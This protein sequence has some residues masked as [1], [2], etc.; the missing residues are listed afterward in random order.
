MSDDKTINAWTTMGG[1]NSRAGRAACAFALSPKAT[2][3]RRAEG[4]IKASPVFSRD[5]VMFIADMTGLVR[6]LPPEGKPLWEKRLDASVFATPAVGDSVLYTATTSGRIYALN[7]A[8][9]D[10]IW[11]VQ[12]PSPDDPR[13]LSDLLLLPQFSLVIASSWG[14][15]FVA[16]DVQKHNER[17]SW[18]A[19][20]NPY[21]A[22]SADA[23]GAIYSL[24]AEWSNSGPNGTRLVRVD[25]QPGKETSLFFDEIK[26][27]STTIH[28]VAAAPVI[29]DERKTVWFITHSGRDST[30]WSLSLETGKEQI[31]LA[32][33]CQITAPPAILPDG[34]T[35]VADMQ[36]VVHNIAPNGE[37]RFRYNTG[38]DYLLS[39]PVC[40][41]DGNIFGGDVIGCLHAISPQGV[42]AIVFEAERGIEARPAFDPAGRLI[43]PATDGAI[44]SF[45]V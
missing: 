36:G 38:G 43:V 31:R 26:D 12:I 1:N 10:E 16:L 8:N 13:I 29:D 33:P 20:T 41:A 30:L 6:A 21:S 15:R 2:G 18:D 19:G 4:R 32:F 37:R 34:G 35:A 23:D 24:R 42:G 39:G 22:A 9:G 3:N 40:D 44:Y 11:N 7:A 45:S 17:F 28:S 25:P 27:K 14:K 5:G